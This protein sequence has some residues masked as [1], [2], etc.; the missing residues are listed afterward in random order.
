M[1]DLWGDYADRLTV[2][3]VTHRDRTINDS[4][5]A[6]LDNIKNNLGFKE[7]STRNGN[8]QK[9]VI[10]ATKTLY[11]SK[12]IAM[13][14]EELLVGDIIANE[15]EHWL[16]VETKITNPIQV[17]GV[18]WLCNQLFRFQ[19]GTSD[20]YE[21]WGVLDS[22]SYSK[23]DDEQIQEVDNRYKIYMPYD[24]NTQRLFV[25][26]R[27]ATNCIYNSDNELILAIY[28]I[29]SCDFVS[30]NYGKGSHLAVFKIESGKYD[31][32]KDNLEELIC[33]YIAPSSSGDDSP[34]LLSC[35]IKGRSVIWTGTSCFYSA[36]F[37]KSDGETLD[38]SVIASWSVSPNLEGITHEVDGNSIKITVA[39]NDFLVGEIVTLSVK[40]TDNLYDVATFEV[41][42]N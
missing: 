14:N 38:D 39:D 21:Q 30:E 27:L 35:S 25:D 31:S 2:G 22:G 15:G 28:K 6:F 40:D 11:K 10:E 37:Y 26:K 12:V 8:P 4:Q 18:A 13:P 16:I 34:S 29:I 19:N 41:E 7:S 9:F 32:S 5:R 1:G 17:S 33:D 36:M 3:G 24:E 20:I 23:T 42:V